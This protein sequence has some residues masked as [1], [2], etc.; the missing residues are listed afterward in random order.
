MCLK[1]HSETPIVRHIKVQGERSPY[2]GDWIY[3]GSRMGK[4]PEV[5][6]STATL[7]KRQKGKCAHCG[8]YF[9]DEDLL[10][11]DHIIP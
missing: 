11:T 1:K 3:W 7:L 4:H 9:K 8:L 5:D 2:D 10:E 6:T